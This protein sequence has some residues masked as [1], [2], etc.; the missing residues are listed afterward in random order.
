MHFY[1]NVCNNCRVTFRDV[2]PFASVAA[3]SMHSN[4]SG[5]WSLD[6]SITALP[7]RRITSSSS[8]WNRNSF[9]IRTAWLLPLLKGFTVFMTRNVYT[10]V[11]TCQVK[12]S[13]RKSLFHV[14]IQDRNLKVKQQLAIEKVSLLLNTEP[15]KMP[16]LRFQ[17]NQSDHQVLLKTSEY[18]S[19]VAP[20]S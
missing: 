16:S 15:N 1:W 6:S 10:H 17:D 8:S 4:L 11:Y 3:P 14:Q 7:S 19:T 2:G 18:D 9:G 12:R 20:G 5:H 13:L